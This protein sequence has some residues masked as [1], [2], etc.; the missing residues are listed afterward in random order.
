MNYSFTVVKVLLIIRIP[1]CSTSSH[2]CQILDKL[3]RCYKL[4][5]DC[6]L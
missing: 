5:E 3:W 1:N 2:R 6:C 4:F